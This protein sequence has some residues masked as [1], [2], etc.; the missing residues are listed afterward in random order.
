[1]LACDCC[2]TALPG[3]LA[4]PTAIPP[5]KQSVAA[6][7]EALSARG[8]MLCT[9]ESCTGGAIAVACTDRAGSS[10]WFERAMV[11]YSNPAKQE[12]LGVQAA[13][14]ERHGAVS[15][16]VVR[17]MA[18]GALRQSKAHWSIAVS[19]VAGPSGGTAEKPVGTVWFA[20]AGPGMCDAA[21]MHFDG[22]REAVRLSSVAYGLAGLLQRL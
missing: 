19:G 22:D 3:F 2:F 15:E 10:Q 17:A 4:I 18:E 8:E 12:M 6:I 21:C 14:I 9:A 11:S 7:A 1:M 20:W 13:T 5:L 16:P